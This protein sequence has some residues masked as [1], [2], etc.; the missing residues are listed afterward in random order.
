[1]ELTLRVAILGTGLIGSSIGL[2]LRRASTAKVPIDVVGYDRYE[3][4]ARQAQKVGAI[5]SL[6]YTSQ[7]AVQGADLVI[8]ATPLLAIRKMMEEIA[9]VVSDDAIIIDTGSTKS[10]VL[11][12]ANELFPAHVGFVGGHPMAGKTQTGPQAA[13]ADLFEGARWIVVPPRS[14]P[15]DAIDV[16]SGLAQMLGAKPSFMDAHEHDAYAAA[17]SHLPLI[18]S[19]ALFRLARSSEAWPELS[20]LASSG[21]RDT[22]RL[23]A[24]EPTMAHDIAITNRVQIVHWIE[25]YRE[26]LLEMQRAIADV[27]HESDL[28]R[29]ISEANAHYTAYREGGVG[30]KEIDQQQFDDMPDIS[31]MDL[32]LGSTLA[33]RARELSKRSDERMQEAERIARAAGR[34][35]RPGN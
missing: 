18:A 14:V 19:T 9:P 8:L 12:W 33:E 6:V 16:V 17:I 1:M 23:T 28:F 26:E 15:P 22:T 13:D 10:E 34:D 30:R 25:R 32:L 35:G 21:F 2:R 27:E 24:T 7:E 5:D 20:L 31:M 4:V 3:D 11:R 29:L